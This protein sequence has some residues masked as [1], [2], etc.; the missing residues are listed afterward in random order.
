MHPKCITHPFLNLENVQSQ[1]FSFTRVKATIEKKQPC[2]VN[3]HDRSVK[4]EDLLYFEHYSEL[5]MDVNKSKM[6]HIYKGET[7]QLS[8]FRG[9]QLPQGMVTIMSSKVYMPF[10]NKILSANIWVLYG[11]VQKLC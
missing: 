4:L 10:V 7:E 9:R 8:I 5:S 6:V 1:L 3:E 11:I 2:V